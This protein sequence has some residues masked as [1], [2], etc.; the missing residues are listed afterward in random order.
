MRYRF[1]STHTLGTV[2]LLQVLLKEGYGR[3]V[4]LFSNLQDPDLTL[5]S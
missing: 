2:V 5:L 4:L 3:S 1:G